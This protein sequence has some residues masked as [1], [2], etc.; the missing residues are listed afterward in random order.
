[1]AG[2][3]D[4]PGAAQVFRLVRRR[5]TKDADTTEVTYGITSL[6]RGD[7]E[8]AELLRLARGHWGIENRL[9]YVR[10]VSFGEDACRC[11]A[12]SL[13]QF[14]AAM[15]NVAIAL[16]AT[17]DWDYVPQAQDRFAACWT[18][19]IALLGAKDEN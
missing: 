1:L 6:S 19:A 5:R 17:T 4:W 2:V 11:R 13:P 3:L 18:E 7:A 10:D 15:R 14:L 16:I 9:H 12:G 8:A